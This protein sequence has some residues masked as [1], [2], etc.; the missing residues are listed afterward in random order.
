[1]NRIYRPFPIQTSPRIASASN[2]SGRRPHPPAPLS[3]AQRLAPRDA[4]WPPH[5][6][7][8][9]RK[10]RS[11]AATLP[12]FSQQPLPPQPSGGHCSETSVS[13]AEG[14]EGP[15]PE[16]LSGRQGGRLPRMLLAGFATDVLT[17]GEGPF[18]FVR[19]LSGE[20]NANPV[21]LGLVHNLRPD[22]PVRHVQAGTGPP[23]RPKPRT[24][25]PQRL[26][27]RPARRHGWVLPSGKKPLA[28]TP[29]AC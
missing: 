6:G 3:A 29:F 22:A 5:G 16:D 14:G 28:P 26:S 8:G 12:H 18:L 20:R 11:G 24:D 7:G 13:A 19:K 25:H 27:P 2:E 15:A 21:S 10:G 23:A 17:G 1:M 9:Q 4:P